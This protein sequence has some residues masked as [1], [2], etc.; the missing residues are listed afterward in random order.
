MEDPG[1]GIQSEPHLWP[2]PQRQQCQVLNPL[3]R[4]RGWRGASKRDKPDHCTTRGAPKV[5]YLYEGSLV[6]LEFVWVL[7]DVLSPWFMYT[8]WSALC[9]L[10]PPST[11]GSH[12]TFTASMILP[13]AECHTDGIQQKVT[14]SG[15][16]PLLNNIHLWFLHVCL[17]L[18]SYFYF[19]KLLST[20]PLSRCI[21][22]STHLLTDTLAASKSWQSP[23][24]PRTHP[25]VGL[26]E[27]S[28]G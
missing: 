8:E 24:K 16:L 22:L 26:C 12:S 4:A 27:D 5:R 14:F 25:S 13:W 15:W 6:V 18:D 28:S 19:F 10:T 3:L 2:M 17:W 20:I 11:T 1:P 23:P 7:T 21:S 9:L